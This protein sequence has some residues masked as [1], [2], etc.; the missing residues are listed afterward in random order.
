MSTAMMQMAAVSGA[1]VLGPVI[2]GVLVVGMLIGAFWLGDVIKSREPA[3]PRPEEQPHLPPGGAVRGIQE[4]REPDEVPTDGRRRL[5]HEFGNL[6]TRPSESTDRP[7]WG[8][9]TSGSFGG[10]GLGAH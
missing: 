7:R 3:P 1:L 9:G 6:Q 10:G 8:K 4:N 5:P 2:V